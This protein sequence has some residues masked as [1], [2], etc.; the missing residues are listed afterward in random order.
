MPSEAEPPEAGA[1]FEDSMKALEA[2]VEQM[3]N[4]ALTLEQSLVAYRRGAELVLLARRSLVRVEQ[5][6]R[7]LE[8]DLLRPFEVSQVDEP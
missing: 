7:I 8:A 3:E 1:G 5:Q 6:V 4:G 2:I